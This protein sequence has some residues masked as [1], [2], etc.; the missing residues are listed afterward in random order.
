MRQPDV[1]TDVVPAEIQ[2]FSPLSNPELRMLPTVLE[3][4]VDGDLVGMTDGFIV[5]LGDDFLVGIREGVE[6]IGL[7]VGVIGRLDGL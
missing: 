4:D 1:I 7:L 3:G 6:V 5:G 2:E